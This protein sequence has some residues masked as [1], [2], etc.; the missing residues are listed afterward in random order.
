MPRTLLAN[1]DYVL[2]VDPRDT[3]IEDGSIVVEDDR[4]AAIGPSAQVA[5][6]YAGATF[7]RVI[8]GRRALAM[9]GLV[10]AHVHVTEQLS[11]GVFPDNLSTRPWVFNW[12]MPYHA[13]ANDEDEE[14]AALC[15]GIEML[16]TG[17]TCF[18][19]MG[20]EVDP[21]PVVRAVEQLGIRGITGR[22]AADIKPAEIPPFWTEETVRRHY[23][24]STEEALRLLEECVARWHGHAGG[25]LRCWVNIQG[26]EPCSPELHVGAR[27]L[28]AAL[29]VGTTYHA[30]STIEEA[31][32]SEKNYG[33][34][35]ITRLHQIGAL[36]PNLVLGHAVAVQDAE[37]A[38]LAA[39]GTKV[40][41][42]PGASLKVAKGATCIGKYPEMLAGG[43]TVA[44]GCDGVSASGTVNMLLQM[45]MVAG[46]FKDARLDANLVP[47]VQALRMA[48]IE[49]AKALL[50]D[51]KI[52]S[53]EV[54]KKADLLLFDL[55]QPEWVPLHDPVQGVVY[56]GSAS[57]L[58]LVLVDGRVVVEN[59]KVLTVDEA[60]IYQEAQRRSSE[61]VARA[62]LRRGATPVTSALYE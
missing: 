18:L 21:A 34:W 40:A 50:W 5:Q 52:G 1:L 30:A 25:R 3:V 39:A 14:V 42:C 46:L 6:Q 60:A 59:R 4:L 17:T 19:D 26:K 2:T 43:V 11:R 29:G 23:C 61:I 32:G 22:N 28:A 16:R 20:A 12:A 55:D 7:D 38:L 31:H 62:G 24:D 27:E 13:A 56:G 47:A 41:F 33:V 57:S 15:A 9:P 44:L 35:P 54:G 10:D 58:K 51:D 45:Y 48:T 37:V 8:D 36:G 49:G 53:L